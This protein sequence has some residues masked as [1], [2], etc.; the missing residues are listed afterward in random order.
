MSSHR[1]VPGSPFAVVRRPF[2]QQVEA[3]IL[4]PN[5]KHVAADAF[6]RLSLAYPLV[7]FVFMPR[8]I[9]TGICLTESRTPTIQK[10]PRSIQSAVSIGEGHM[11]TRKIGSMA[12]LFGFVLSGLVAQAPVDLMASQIEADVC[13][14]CS[15]ETDLRAAGLLQNINI[16]EKDDRIFVDRRKI[17]AFN[18]VVK[19][20]AK[21]VAGSG[22]LYKS[23]NY[24][25]TSFHVAFG[26]RYYRKYRLGEKNVD[27]SDATLAKEKVTVKLG[28]TDDPDKFAEEVEAT[29]VVWGN[30]EGTDRADDWALLKLNKCVK[31]YTALPIADYN[32][33]QVATALD[34]GATVA[35]LGY[36]GDEFL[37][38]AHGKQARN[39]L[40]G[41]FDCNVDKNAGE[42]MFR[43][44]CSSMPGGSGGPF[45]LIENNVPKVVGV[46][47]GP[48][49]NVD[50]IIPYAE[51][52]NS[53]SNKVVPMYYITKQINQF[54]A[55]HP[56]ALKPMSGEEGLNTKPALYESTSHPDGMGSRVNAF[57]DPV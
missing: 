17:T 39:Q 28:A 38:E 5:F 42:T 54:F 20:A 7:V 8:G 19:V 29:P 35:T 37:A 30:Y 18:G 24:V 40:F 31:G 25:L 16:F 49:M 44:N 47:K 36:Y 26:D 48:A 22:F 56:E 51:F 1:A 13:V 15:S 6:E 11:L 53:N 34:R 32:P 4:Q 12:F 57:L 3:S 2:V 33:S 23:C 9:D 46:M 27:M 41:D 14:A 55:K 45:L 43:T 10:N 50:G 21:T 52:N